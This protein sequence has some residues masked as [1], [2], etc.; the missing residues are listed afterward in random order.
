MI[1]IKVLRVV[2]ALFALFF[3]SYA[4]FVR[5]TGT[6]TNDERSA[7]VM[8]L[9]LFGVGVLMSVLLYYGNRFFQKFMD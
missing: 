4:I 5:T 3:L 7:F 2:I 6:G 8:S 9:V 1:V